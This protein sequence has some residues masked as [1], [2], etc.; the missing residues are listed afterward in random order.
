M[1]TD[2]WARERRSMLAFLA[3]LWLGG[4]AAARA[5][6]PASVIVV[7]DGSGSMAGNIEGVRGSKVVLAREAVRRALAKVAPQT[8]VGLAAFG[9]RRGD[10]GDVELLRARSGL[11]QHR[12]LHRP[13]PQQ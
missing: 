4:A 6:E 9:H 3:L 10:C 8:R 2:H 13:A 12:R 5:Q 1:W 7:F 11:A